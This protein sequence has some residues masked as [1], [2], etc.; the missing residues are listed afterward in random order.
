MKAAS[1]H[2]IYEN[3]Q[4]LIARHGDRI[5]DGYFKRE[6]ECGGGRGS[7]APRPLQ[8]IKAQ[9]SCLAICQNK[10]NIGILILASSW[11]NILLWLL[12]KY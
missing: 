9:P 1:L 4:Y 10:V 8:V 6:R 5:S 7:Y 3:K 2:S 11:L 12:L